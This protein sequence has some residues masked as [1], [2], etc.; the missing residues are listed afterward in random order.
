MA[1][2]P[3]RNK[4]VAKKRR[5]RLGPKES[6]AREIRG[7]L[8]ELYPDGA[9]PRQLCEWIKSK[10]AGQA[11]DSVYLVPTSADKFYV[12]NVAASEKAL[13]SGLF[14]TLSARGVNEFHKSDV[15]FVPLDNWILE[16]ERYETLLKIR[17]FVQFRLAKTF[18]TWK[19]V[20]R[21]QKFSKAAR[22]LEENS[23]VLGNRHMR[24]C[25]LKLQSHLAKI[26]TMGA[27]D[28]L[29]KTAHVSDFLEYQIKNIERFAE[30]FLA[31]RELA[32]K[33][34][35]AASQ[36]AFS[37]CGFSYDEYEGELAALRMLKD[38]TAVAV[39]SSMSAGSF[40]STHQ[41]P[42]KLTFIEQ[43]NKRQCCIKITN[44]IR[45]VDFVIRGVLFEVC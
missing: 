20:V 10:G 39:K 11:M 21:R 2:R 22:S 25:Y 24:A 31:F 14:L 26:S 42:K 35:L 36:A 4:V 32:V 6:M 34:T 30:S 28:V 40:M 15:R 27:T 7:Q 8:G 43:A 37:E 33:L 1:S 17:L 23:C 45:L 5:D 41:T 38:S 12:Y 16:H 19:N 44:F 18:G 3:Q 13:E 9:T 29:S